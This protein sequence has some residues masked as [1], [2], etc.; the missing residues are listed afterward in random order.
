M[1]ITTGVSFLGQTN[2]TADNLK[3]LQGDMDTL[4]RQLSTQKLNNTMAGLGPDTQL[5]LQ[6]HADSDQLT[7]YNANI[8]S[9]LS[10][11]NTMS[12]TLTEISNSVN[13]MTSTLEAQPGSGN[14]DMTTITTQAQQLLDYVVDLSNMNIAGRYLFAGTDS[15]NQPI[16][17]KATLNAN[18]QSQL[19]GWFN[20]SITTAQLI[21][22][23]NGFSGTQLGYSAS[24]SGADDV[25]THIDKNLDLSYGSVADRNGVQDAVRALSLLA[26]LRNLAPGDVPTGANLDSVI[27]NAVS[28]TQSAMQKMTDNQTLLS[29]KLDLVKNVEDTHSQTINTYAAILQKK[30]DADPATIITQLQS[31]QTQLQASYEATRMVNQLSLVNFL[32]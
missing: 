24:I 26:N 32:N 14:Y 2:A 9:A 21:S 11:I 27:A 23:T 19:T 3:S 8:D 30:E 29:S 13:S 4:T 5:V 7:A 31:L 17:D 18:M 15:T 16:P 20:G 28:M 1:T 12:S 25:T 6:L 10:R 22:N